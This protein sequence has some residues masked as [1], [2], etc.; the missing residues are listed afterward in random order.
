MLKTLTGRINKDLKESQINWKVALSFIPIAFFTY[1]FHEFGHWVVGEILGNDMTLSL[2]SSNARTGVLIKEAHNLYI[3]IGGPAFTI[4]QA[5]IFL[6]ITKHKK[7]VYTYSVTF[8]AVF[9][10]FFSIVLGGFSQ[11]DEARI[12][13]MLNV[14]KYLIATIVLSILLLII[15]KC[16]RIMKLN[17]KAVGYFITLSTLVILLVIVVINLIDK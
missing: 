1:L 11:Q 13:L 7:S 12:S 5:L 9:S 14:N 3:S 2:N 6:L 16:N 8:F 10:R 15:W 17:F 4:L